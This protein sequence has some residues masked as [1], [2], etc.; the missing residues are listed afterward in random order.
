MHTPAACEFV[1]A[2]CVLCAPTC[3]G[4]LIACAA[5]LMH[6]IRVNERQRG[7]GVTL[8]NISVLVFGRGRRAERSNSLKRRFDRWQRDDLHPSTPPLRLS[9]T[10]KQSCGPSSSQVCSPSSRAPLPAR[11]Q[12]N[13][14]SCRVSA[15]YSKGKKKSLVLPDG[16]I[17]R[18]RL[19]LLNIYLLDPLNHCV[20]V[21]SLL[22]S[23]QRSSQLL[24]EHRHL[25][26]TVC[27]HV[28]C[29]SLLAADFTLVSCS[30]C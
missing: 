10:H 5:A 26:P 4:G 11:P 22:S 25:P 23:A 19:D 6:F 29:Y 20:P 2:A 16:N 8:V 3:E 30:P 9:P 12:R 13:E 1:Y 21:N 17:S 24:L 7:P 15:A 27:F 14:L 18:S 28:L